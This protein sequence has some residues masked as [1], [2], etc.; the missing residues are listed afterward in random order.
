MITVSTGVGGVVFTALTGIMAEAFGMQKAMIYLAAF[1][2]LS[3]GAVLL[4]GKRE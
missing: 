4:L 1:F 2:I 3:I